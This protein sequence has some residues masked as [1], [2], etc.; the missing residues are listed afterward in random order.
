MLLLA[1]AAPF[2]AGVAGFGVT[3]AEEDEEDIL[4]FLSLLES[5]DTE[6]DGFLT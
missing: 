3:N 5:T 4:V 6:H 2:V 1:I